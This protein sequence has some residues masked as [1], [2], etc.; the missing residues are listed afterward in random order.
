MITINLGFCWKHFILCYKLFKS[1][2]SNKKKTRK[3]EKKK[4]EGENGE[5]EERIGQPHKVVEKY[6][7][8]FFFFFSFLLYIVEKLV[9]TLNETLDSLDMHIERNQAKCN[10]TQTPEHKCCSKEMVYKMAMHHFSNV[11]KRILAHTNRTY[12]SKRI[13]Q[14]AKF[15]H[16]SF[17][18]G[19]INAL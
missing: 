10:V 7:L 3:K 18:Q 2:T 13:L 16:K 15:W 6:S 8:L 19:S 12:N 1:V 17:Y 5:T 9:I 4:R 14:S 11:H